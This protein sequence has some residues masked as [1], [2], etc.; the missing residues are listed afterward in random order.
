MVNG[1]LYLNSFETD[2]MLPY[3]LTI[4]DMMLT[5]PHQWLSLQRLILSSDNRMD[6]D[7]IGNWLTRCPNLTHILFGPLYDNDAHQF[8]DM[9]TILNRYCPLL[10]SFHIKYL[11]SHQ[12]TELAR[13]WLTMTST[14][15]TSLIMERSVINGVIMTSIVTS[16]PNLQ[17]LTLKSMEWFHSGTRNNKSG[18]TVNDTTLHALQSLTNLQHLSIHDGIEDDDMS[19]IINHAAA[20]LTHLEI[21]ALI[22]LDAFTESSSRF[23][24]LKTLTLTAHVFD[25]EQANIN[26]MNTCPSLTRLRL[27]RHDYYGDPRIFAGV[28][29]GIELEWL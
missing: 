14:K 3:S 23:Q 17:S 27:Y 22:P 18:T 20:T 21:P 1:W 16:F 11:T 6:H 8:N 7:V 9:T 24:R 12:D 15:L 19:I 26:G 4:D 5:W 10:S 25:V 2:A 13:A 28:R 29:H